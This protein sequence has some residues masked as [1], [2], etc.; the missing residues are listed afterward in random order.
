V[1]VQPSH[2][3][4]SP[5]PEDC[6]KDSKIAGVC[7]AVNERQTDSLHQHSL[8]DGDDFS[9]KMKHARKDG[10]QAFHL[11]QP[12][13]CSASLRACDA[14]GNGG[15]SQALFRNAKSGFH[16]SYLLMAQQ[17]LIPIH[18]RRP[19]RF[20]DN[21]AVICRCRQSMHGE[22][23]NLLPVNIEPDVDFN[24]SPPAV[25]TTGE[26]ASIAHPVVDS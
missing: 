9:G 16:S 11:L 7:L 25:R 5:S 15:V 10:W 13:L 14:Q 6:G 2:T 4:T 26:I 1:E 17:C 24:I 8:D 12:A 23:Q 19:V 20:V 22:K 3:T 21:T 18:F